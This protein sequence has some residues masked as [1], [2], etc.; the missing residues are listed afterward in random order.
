ML[1]LPN[2]ARAVAKETHVADDQAVL[3]PVRVPGFK[4]IDEGR[5]THTK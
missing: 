5:M 1:P 3:F 2:P 4:R